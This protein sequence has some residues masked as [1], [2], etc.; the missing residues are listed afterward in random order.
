MTQEAPE[1]SM[2]IDCACHFEV[3]VT[4]EDILP[5]RDF[6]LEIVEAVKHG[7]N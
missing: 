2:P 6:L 1:N 7:T 4:Q 3:N 5:I